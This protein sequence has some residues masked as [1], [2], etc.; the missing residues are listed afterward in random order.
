MREVIQ[1]KQIIKVAKVL[2]YLMM[3][4]KTLGKVTR[5]EKRS[6]KRKETTKKHGRHGAPVPKGV[7]ETESIAAVLGELCK[8]TAATS[9]LSSQ[10]Q[11]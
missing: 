6:T 7:Y 11:G 5:L 2:E 4:R 1:D 3:Q 10:C 9:W 8:T